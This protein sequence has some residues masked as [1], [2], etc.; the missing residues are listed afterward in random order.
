MI[1]KR[2]QLDDVPSISELTRY[3]DGELFFADNISSVPTLMRVFQ[4]RFIAFVICVDGELELELNSNR[5]HIRRYD[6][7][8]VEPE[9]V[10]NL[11]GHSSDFSCKILASPAETGFSFINKRL[12]DA[13]MRVQSNPVIHFSEAEFKLMH[14]YYRL[15]DYKLNNPELSIDRESMAMI[16]RAYTLD[17]LL[18]IS[19]HFEVDDP[20]MLRQGD[21]LFRNFLALLADENNLSRSVKWYADKL[22]VS[23]KYLTTICRQHGNNTASDLIAMNMVRRIKQLLLYSDLSIKEISTRMEFTNLSFFGKYV[24]KHLGQSPNAYRDANGYGR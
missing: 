19:R 13:A 18:C 4:V 5:F 24:K 17:L 10:I 21:K 15:V 20:S 12:F 14:E 3:Y 22:C 6:A 23:S 16:F 11:I 2:L 8:F 7:L 9:A 1:I